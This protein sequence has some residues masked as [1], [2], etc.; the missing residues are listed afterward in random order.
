[1]MVALTTKRYGDTFGSAV[2]VALST[3]NHSE[4]LV[5]NKLGFDVEGGMCTSALIG[6]YM[7]CNTPRF[8][9][10]GR[11]LD[12]LGKAQ[13]QLVPLGV[14]D[15]TKEQ[16]DQQSIAAPI[17]WFACEEPQHY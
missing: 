2:R 17:V 14:E 5:P 9:V 13:L 10:D 3:V 12:A 4:D 6:S 15:R 1:M 11:R 7:L 8:A 16:Q